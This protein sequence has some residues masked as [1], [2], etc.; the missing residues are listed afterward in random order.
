MKPGDSA[1]LEVYP[2]E[3]NSRELER[4]GDDAKS[5]YALPQNGAYRVL[6]ASETRSPSSNNSGNASGS[7]DWPS[8]GFA[9][10]AANDPRVDTGIKPEQL[11]IDFGPFGQKADLRTFL[12][13]HFE[14][15][16]DEY[17]PS[18]LG[19]Q[20]DR[21]EFRI[22]R[23]GAY[24]KVFE[25]DESM[26]LLKKAIESR[27]KDVVVK[28]LPYPAYEDVAYIMSTRREFLEGVGWRGLRWIVGVGQ[29]DSCRPDLG[30]FF[31]G[32]SNDGRYFIM[33]RARVSHPATQQ[34]WTADC[35]ADAEAVK[36]EELLQRNLA[37]A[38]PSSFQPNLDQLDAVIRSLKLR[39]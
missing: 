5:V 32:L 26:E 13:Q 33:I 28:D 24:K 2:P 4:G 27:G 16:V 18:N 9:F 6:V 23:V 7:K 19:V 10:L 3:L 31:R 15:Y 1:R 29:D 36:L 11:S 12:Y 30:Y 38:A 20:N 39:P 8:L 25:S 22:M 35:I 17:W 37:T 34:V 14:G 21:I